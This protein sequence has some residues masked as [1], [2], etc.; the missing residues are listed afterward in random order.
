MYIQCAV[1]ASLTCTTLCL[2][3]VPFDA[4][5]RISLD[6]NL[7]MILENPGDTPLALAHRCTISARVVAKT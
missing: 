2:V 6:T 3:Q 5:V 7:A 4:R 1:D